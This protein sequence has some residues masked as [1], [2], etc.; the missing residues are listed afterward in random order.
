MR[1]KRAWTLQSF[2]IC[3]FCNAVL[4]GVFFFV[5]RQVLAGVHR[6]LDPLL[7]RGASG[8]PHDVHAGLMHL[9]R[10]IG[11]A[12]GF[13]AAFIFGLGGGMSLIL[14]LLVNFRGRS[15][16]ERARGEAVPSLEIP[17]Q[18]EKVPTPE[19]SYIEPSPAA[20]VEMLGLLQR[21]GRLIDFLQED[22]NLYED[23]QIGAAVRTIHQGCKEALEEHV[24]LTPVYDEDEGTPVTVAPG[25]DS[26]AVRLTG[27]VAGDPPF[28]GTVRHRGWRV[29]RIEL[30]RSLAEQ[31]QDWI[32]SPAEVEIETVQ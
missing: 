4:I 3:F 32:L 14:W 27:N 26:R 6:W 15:L 11:G 1:G 8:L 31:K 21:R 13:L 29:V 10:V 19:P 16:L 7:D 23:A 5:A 24:A 22:L 2:L 25:F 30:P 20:A 9:D 28:H 18:E 17:P 12:E